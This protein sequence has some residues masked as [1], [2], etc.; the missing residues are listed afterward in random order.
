MPNIVRIQPRPFEATNP[1]CLGTELRHCRERNT[2]GEPLY[3][4]GGANVIRWRFHPQT[5]QRQSNAKIVR[6]SDGAAG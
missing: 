4:M 2:A 3:E 5:G 1:E 6:W